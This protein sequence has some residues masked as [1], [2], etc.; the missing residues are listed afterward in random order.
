MRKGYIWLVMVVVVLFQLSPSIS[1]A[2]APSGDNPQPEVCNAPSEMM[3]HYFDFQNEAKNILLWSEVNS[4]RF[5]LSL[6]QWGLFNTK[7]LDLHSASAIDILAWNIV[8]GGQSFVSNTVTS[9]VLLLLAS[10]SVVQSNVEWFSILFKDRPIVREYKEML[11]IET[12]LFDVAYFRSKQINMTRPFDSD[13][14]EQLNNL[15]EEYQ[16]VWLLEK[17]ESQVKIKDWT[18]MAD[19]LLD[20]VSMNTSMKHFISWG[21]NYWKMMLLDYNWCAWTMESSRD[22]VRGNSV[23]KF[24]QDAINQLQEDYKDVRS[25]WACN[26]YA[27]FTRSTITKTV[28][29]NA[30]NMKTA[31]NDVKDAIERLKDA[32]IGKWRWN[33]KTP[34][35][36]ITE[37]EMAQLKAYWWPQWTCSGIGVKLSKQ[38][39]ET[40][41]YSKEKKAQDTQKER[42]ETP[43]K[44]ANKPESKDVTIWNLWERLQ[45]LKNTK[46]REVLYRRVFGES[47]KFNADF[48][49]ELNDDFVSVYTLTMSQ[50]AQDQEDGIAADLSDILPR[51][52]WVLDQLWRTIKNTTSENK[53]DG[54]NYN[55]QQIADYQWVSS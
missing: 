17:W 14:I 36:A 50:Y 1:Y 39:S 34:C 20:L 52:K 42:N 19:I 6:S 28:N 12:A 33:L 8:W 45:K 48:L 51:G 41:N 18:S 30:E 10:A 49:F 3:Q 23:F 43:L 4:R 40:R 47:V 35:D 32:L 31:V 25:F 38:L 54:L 55:L 15:I 46:E 22:C 16:W 13:L 29:N 2:D 7:V 24:S 53:D 27:T 11:D 26:K 5:N 44:F 37:Y 21:S 9:V